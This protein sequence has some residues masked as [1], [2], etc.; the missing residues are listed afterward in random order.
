[1]YLVQSGVLRDPYVEQSITF[2]FALFTIRA[3]AGDEISIMA[4][5]GKLPKVALHVSLREMTAPLLLSGV[6]DIQAVHFG[7]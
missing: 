3:P 1:M 5:C 4:R 2:R 7:N 6:Q